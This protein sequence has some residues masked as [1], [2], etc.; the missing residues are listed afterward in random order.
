M[1]PSTTVV[2]VK[3]KNNGN[4]VFILFLFEFEEALSFLITLHRSDVLT[5]L[6]FS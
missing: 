6:C 3:M 4:V 2:Q 1:F 5:L